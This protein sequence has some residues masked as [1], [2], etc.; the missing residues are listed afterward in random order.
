MPARGEVW[1]AD[2]GLVEKTRPVLVLNVP[3][4]DT[5]RSLY[6]VIPRTTAVRGSQ[7]EVEVPVSFLKEGAFV[8]QQPVTV[9]P[10]RLLRQLGVLSSE[11]MTLVEA[12]VRHW[13]GL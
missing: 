12:G 7:F 10:V 3:F 8:V 1:L 11:Q 5:D 9:P 2:L 4:A 13:L 6:T